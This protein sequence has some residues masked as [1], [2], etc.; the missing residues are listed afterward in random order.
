MMIKVMID[1]PDKLTIGAVK[2]IVTNMLPQPLHEELLAKIDKCNA[3]L[4]GLK[5]IDKYIEISFAN[6]FTAREE[7]D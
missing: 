2:A 6:G 1:S 5:V 4:A 7:I 3:P